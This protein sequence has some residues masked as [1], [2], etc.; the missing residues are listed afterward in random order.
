[1]FGSMAFTLLNSELDSFQEVFEVD[2]G[3][4]SVVGWPASVGDRER[5]RL[6]KTQQAVGYCIFLSSWVYYNHHHHHHQP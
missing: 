5:E 3:P 4:M 1:M 6:K 2:C